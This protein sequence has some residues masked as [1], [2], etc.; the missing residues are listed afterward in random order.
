M[1][2]FLSGV[3]LGAVL[4]LAASLCHV[5]R[6]ADDL[7]EQWARGSES[8]EAEPDPMDLAEWAQ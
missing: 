7:I 6:E 3:G 8:A 1:I 5:A 2:A 4:V